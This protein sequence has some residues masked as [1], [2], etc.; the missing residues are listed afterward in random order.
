MA[1]IQPA[2]EPGDE[3][4]DAGLGEELERQVVRLD[5]TV[6]WTIGLPA[7]SGLFPEGKGFNPC[8]VTVG[9]D[10][11]IYLVLNGPDRVVKLVPAN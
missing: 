4:D 3:A 11:A 5:G 7:E 8:A 10:G 2:A 9:P 6:E 1:P